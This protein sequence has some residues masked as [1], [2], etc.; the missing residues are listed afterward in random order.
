MPAK[1]KDP[2]QEP[3][4]EPVKKVSKPRKAK[5]VAESATEI[6]Q[7]EIV[8]QET[9]KAR[10][11]NF[12]NFLSIY[13]DDEKTIE[14]IA[15]QPAPDPETFS[16]FAQNQSN[17]VLFLMMMKTIRDSILSETGIAPEQQG[18]E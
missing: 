14:A 18:S 10:D 6:P 7:P 11:N 5:A 8:D 16:A 9:K 12:R 17:H 1:K 15:S 4:K 3:E 13:F 2:A